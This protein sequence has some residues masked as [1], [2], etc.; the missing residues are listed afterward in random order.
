M[1]DMADIQI[2]EM[3]LSECQYCGGLCGEHE[4]D[5][6]SLEELDDEE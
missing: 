3:M 2:E 4:I 1:G 6:L 5:C